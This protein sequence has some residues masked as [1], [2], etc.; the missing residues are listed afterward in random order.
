M[1]HLV[2]GELKVCVKKFLIC[3]WRKQKVEQNVKE[4]VKKNTKRMCKYIETKMSKLAVTFP[5]KWSEV[6]QSCPTL[7]NSMDGNLPGSMVHGIF[8]ARILEWAAI[9]LSRGSSQP[10]DRTWVSC[11][12]G[13]RITIWA[14]RNSG[15]HVLTKSEK[16]NQRFSSMG[17][18]NVQIYL[19]W[20]R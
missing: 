15:L 12:A 18:F 20:G 10:R 11:I 3:S 17:R 2:A 13:R 4:R 8:Q 9:S 16:G 6:T 19:S 14:T 7:C 5:M 1:F